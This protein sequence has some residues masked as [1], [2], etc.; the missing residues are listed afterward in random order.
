MPIEAHEQEMIVPRAKP[1]LMAATLAK[2]RHLRGTMTAAERTL[3]QALRNHQLCG[4]KFRRQHPIGPYIVDFYCHN[5][6]LVIELD[7]EHH[8]HRAQYQNDCA[9]T[10]VLSGLGL[11]VMR[12]ENQRVFENLLTVLAEIVQVLRQSPR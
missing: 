8:R 2:A 12:F 10:R 6:R 7:G 4:L 9:R 5:A 3:W 1:K 11:K